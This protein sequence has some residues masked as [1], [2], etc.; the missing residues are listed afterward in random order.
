MI[1]TE[2]VEELNAW[3][4]TLEPI[5]R[6]RHFEVAPRPVFKDFEFHVWVSL[7]AAPY[8]DIIRVLNRLR[9]DVAHVQSLVSV[10]CR[11]SHPKQ[12]VALGRVGR[13]F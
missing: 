8:K 7:V 2:S 6:L 9:R 4:L 13:R 1:S 3:E 5:E 11:N 12:I 10:V